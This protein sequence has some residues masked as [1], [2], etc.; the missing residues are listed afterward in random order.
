MKQYWFSSLNISVQSSVLLNFQSLW[1][2]K[3]VKLYWLVV[4]LFYL[5]VTAAVRTW[6]AC[7]G[8]PS[9]H[10]RSQ[11]DPFCLSF[12]QC[13]RG[14]ETTSGD[15]PSRINLGQ[16]ICAWWLLAGL[17]LLL[18]PLGSAHPVQVLQDDS[19]IRAVPQQLIPDMSLVVFWKKP[20]ILIYMWHRNKKLSLWYL[21]YTFLV[22]ILF[23]KLSS[24]MISP[25]KSACC[26]RF[27]W[28]T[29]QKRLLFQY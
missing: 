29:F 5:F 3:K 19:N 9:S 21:F 23:Q 4:S 7:P 20:T 10:H 11:E 26:E 25:L 17:D 8:S 22:E 24:E 2:G 13:G 16:D 14:A 27:N 1:E 28:S 15:C 12:Q 18:Q 6:S